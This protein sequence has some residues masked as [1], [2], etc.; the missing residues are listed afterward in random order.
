MTRERGIALH[1]AGPGAATNNLDEDGVLRNRRQPAA[2]TAQC[3]TKVATWPS[4]PSRDDHAA[5]KTFHFLFFL[6]SLLYLVQEHNRGLA[7]AVTGPSRV[8][9]R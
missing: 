6:P 1:S 4:S 8:Q 5:V 9:R 3:E 2:F 7:V